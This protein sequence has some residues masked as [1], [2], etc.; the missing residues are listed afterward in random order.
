M[1][2]VSENIEIPP[3]QVMVHEV[4]GGISEGQ[5][6]AAPARL[7]V[8][9]NELCGHPWWKPIAEFNNIDDPTQIPAGTLLRIP[10]DWM[11]K[12]AQ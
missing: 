4:T 2:A 12:E 6:E 9:A 3:D 1:P 11:S 10:N 5:E 8:I 7:D